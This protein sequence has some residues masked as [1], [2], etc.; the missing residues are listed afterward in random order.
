MTGAQHNFGVVTMPDGARR[1][2]NSHANSRVRILCGKSVHELQMGDNSV[3]D[4]SLTLE[5]GF[6]TLERGGGGPTFLLLKT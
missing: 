5:T 6:P 2:R 4:P 3:P 1:V